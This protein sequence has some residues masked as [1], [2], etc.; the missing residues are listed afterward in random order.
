MAT[1]ILSERIGDANYGLSLA[2]RPDSGGSKGRSIDVYANFYPVKINF[3]KLAYQYDVDISCTFVRKD[4]SL[5]EFMARREQR[6]LL[7]ESFSL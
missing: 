6:K 2:K 4:G 5:G 1:S 3:D 7:I